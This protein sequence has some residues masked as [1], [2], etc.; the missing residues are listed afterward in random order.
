MEITYKHDS[1][2]VDW[3]HMVD[4]LEDDDFHNGR[5]VRQMQLSFENSQ[6]VCIAYDGERIIGT[7]RALSDGVGNAYVVDV[8]THSTY[9]RQGIATR[10]MEIIMEALPGQHVY[11]FTDDSLG[12]YEKLGFK[13]QGVGMAQIVG[14]YLQND[15]R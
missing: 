12:F 11:L 10:M 8:W 15:T 6:S 13:P 3:Q 1:D 14:D 9:R 7:A 5:S 2:G 4:V